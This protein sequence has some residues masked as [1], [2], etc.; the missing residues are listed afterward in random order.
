MFAL[1]VR[2]F[3]WLAR[4]PGAPQVFDA[5]NVAWTAIFH[6][7]RLTAMEAIE[8][9]A[10]QLPDVQLRV[11]RFGG[12]EFVAFGRELGH[13][14]GNGLLDIC[15]GRETAR[16]LISERKAEPHHVLGKSSWISFWVRCAD[17]GHKGLEL[18]KTAHR[19]RWAKNNEKPP[20][21][22]D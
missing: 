22:P 9:A 19:A 13:L 11:H 3:R 16:R 21:V 14:H 15:V 8:T 17:D 18:I 10:L 5:L 7:Q 1:V 6:R 4:I 20:V 12:I 2:Y